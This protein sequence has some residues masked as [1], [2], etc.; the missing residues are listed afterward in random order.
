MS[1]KVCMQ[2]EFFDFVVFGIE[3]KV[4]EVNNLNAG[5]L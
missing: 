5:Q 1:R 3:E 2:N 4:L